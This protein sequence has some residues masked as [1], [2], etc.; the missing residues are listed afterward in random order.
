MWIEEDEL[1]MICLVVQY[2]SFRSFQFLLLLLV[3]RNSCEQIY[4]ADRN[5]T[6]S[7]FLSIESR[8]V[9]VNVPFSMYAQMYLWKWENIFQWYF[10]VFTIVDSHRINWNLLLAFTTLY[11]LHWILLL[12]NQCNNLDSYQDN[13]T[14]MMEKA[15][16][17]REISI[18]VNL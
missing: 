5:G 1:W 7:R 9:Y 17:R 15:T 8:D 4:F 12:I 6:L 13:V 3:T 18:I 14:K 2:I 10:A 11:V 16:Y